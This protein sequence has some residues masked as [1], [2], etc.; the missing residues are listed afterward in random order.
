MRK[1][2]VMIPLVIL[3]IIISSMVVSGTLNRMRTVDFLHIL[4]L[5]AAL[6]VLLKA[7]VSSGSK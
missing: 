7:L 1:K 4:S 2:Q 6:G 3:V 5:G